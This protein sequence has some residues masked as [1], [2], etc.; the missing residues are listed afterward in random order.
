MG[1]PGISESTVAQDP[2]EQFRLWWDLA[3]SESQMNEPTAMSL[4]TCDTEGRPSNRIV[5]LKHW[6]RRGFVFYT[7]YNS[8]KGRELTA[9]PYAELLFWW[10]K[11]RRQV[12][13][14]GE[15]QRLSEVESDAYFA[16]R[17]RGSQ[18]GAW[19]SQQSRPLASRETLSQRVKELDAEFGDGPIPRPLH[20]GGFRVVP[21]RIEFWDD[22]EHRLHDRLVYQRDGEQWKL[23]RLYP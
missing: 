19:A 11:L 10:D 18:I 17:P 22:G 16:N 23:E 3:Q 4:A 20:W 12:R 7:N 21:V 14:N 6:D 8:R 5:L 13:V 1:R 15:V 2:F 9:N